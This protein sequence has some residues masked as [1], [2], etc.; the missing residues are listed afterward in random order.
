MASSGNWFETERKAFDLR[1][2]SLVSS[3]TNLTYTA[4]VGGASDN[5]IIDRVI[6][7]D[8]SS[9]SVMTI[10]LPDGKYYGQRLLVVCDAYA[11]TGTV[12][13][14]VDTVAGTDATPL[15]GAGGYTI[16]EWHGSTAGGWDEIKASAT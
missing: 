1:T 9:G 12:N 10:T 5:F 14:D 16:L 7:V 2:K 3:T 11:A 15:T 4:R 8:S 13:V 6:R